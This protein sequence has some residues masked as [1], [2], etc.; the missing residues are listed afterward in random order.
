MTLDQILNL[1]RTKSYNSRTDAEVVAAVNAALA[2]IYD[3]IIKENRG[4]WIK[5]D[6]TT[7]GLIVNQEEY[8]LPLDLE[9]LIRVRERPD[10]LP[11]YLLMEPATSLTDESM[12]AATGTADL[13]VADGPVSQYVYFGPYL[14]AAA[15]V[16]DP[17]GAQK[18]RVGPIPSSAR[19]VELVY[20]VK[21]IEIVD[22][23]S[24]LM[25]PDEGS[26]RFALIDIAV[27]ELVQANDDSMAESYRAS[28]ERKLTMFLNTIRDRQFQQVGT[29]TPYLSDLD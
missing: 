27:A 14:D 13:T 4:Y 1:V 10:A 22:E 26:G 24:Y 9:A 8:A 3:F 18:I 20:T 5:W 12:I 29:Q 2:Y 19:Q 11:Q 15:A 23:S 17:Q 28:G 25:I 16:A 7:V 6:T 21:K